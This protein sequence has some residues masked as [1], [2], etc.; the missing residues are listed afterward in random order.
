MVRA[1]FT[2]ALPNDP[3]LLGRL[4]TALQVQADPPISLRPSGDALVAFESSTTDLVLRCR[5]I[6]ALEQAAGP[7]WQTIARPIE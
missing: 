2:M 7:D 3:E 6:Q 1:R 5:V 4:A